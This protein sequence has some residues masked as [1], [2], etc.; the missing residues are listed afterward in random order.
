MIVSFGNHADVAQLVEHVLGKN[1]VS[2]SIPDIGSTLT[3]PDATMLAVGVFA[4]LAQL[5]EHRFRKA[6]VPSSN[7]GGGSKVLIDEITPAST[8][9]SVTHSCTSSIYRIGERLWLMLLSST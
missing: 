6:G 5:V 7:L 9:S 1:E 4:T 8:M 3:T 2:G